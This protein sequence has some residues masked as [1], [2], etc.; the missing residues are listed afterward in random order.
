[1]NSN[2]TT[3]QGLSELEEHFL[4]FRKNIIGINAEFESPYGTKKIVYAD[5]IASG[6]LYGPIEDKIRNK[7]GQMVGNTHSE[8][9]ET[10]SCMTHA[11]HLAHHLIK[12]HVNASQDDVIIT[13]GSGMTSVLSKFQRI[14]GVRLP[15]RL[16]QFCNIPAADRPVVFITHMEHHSNHTP[17]LESFADVVLLTPN[18]DLLV[19]P[20]RL[21]EEIVKYK[22]RKIKI[23]SFSACSNVTGIPTPYYELSEIMHDYGGSCFVDFA[24]SAP[25]VKIDMHPKN[26]KQYLDAVFFS[27]HKFLGGPGSP[28]VLVFNKKLYKNRIPDHPGGGTV[29]W[30]NPWGGHHY[31]DDIEIREDG[32]TPGFL[33]TIKAALAIKLKEEMGVQQM[34][35]REKYLV[36]K[37]FTGLRAIPGVHIL[38][39]KCENRLSVFSFYVEG[40]HHNLIVRVLNDRFGI[41]VRGGCSCA[42]TYGHF[43]LQVTKTYSKKITDAI[44]RGDNSLKPGWIR[45]SLHPVMTDAEL[46]FILRA[47]NEVV[48]NIEV[49]KKDYKYSNEVNEF[50]HRSFP[51]KKP[52]DFASWFDLNS[53]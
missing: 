50:F 51:I 14:L 29:T 34:H 52:K 41:Q 40:I 12:K 8:S 45:L 10:G 42:G 6:R 20:E 21:R 7:F 1:M 16:K 49:W 11:Y 9:T 17:W 4:T 25:Y 23:G 13:A 22:D 46:D 47:I 18:E 36:A 39:D 26:K 43:L 35:T 37:T 19:C 2:T 5:W 27:P 38:A 32:G 30:T 3:S 48:V 28:G 44:D 33:Q 15:E 53:N 24:A 31:V